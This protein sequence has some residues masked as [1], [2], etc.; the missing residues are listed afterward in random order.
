MLGL[1][2][3]K[4]STLAN[5]GLCEKKIGMFDTPKYVHTKFGHHSYHQVCYKNL[6][7]LKTKEILYMKDEYKLSKIQGEARV[8]FLERRDDVLRHDS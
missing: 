3:Q 7:E 8:E 4:K 5:C 1:K 2:R 6:M